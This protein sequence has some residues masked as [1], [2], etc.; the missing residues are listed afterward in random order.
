MLP[1]KATAL[2]RT[3]HSGPNPFSS[4]N[5]PYAIPSTKKPAKTG[6]ACGNAA[7]SA[8]VNLF[9]LVSSNFIFTSLLIYTEY[10]T[11]DG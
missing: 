4:I 7:E 9:F 8:C 5:M 11:A 6:N 10:K 1:Q 2:M 3:D